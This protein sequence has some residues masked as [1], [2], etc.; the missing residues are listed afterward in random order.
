MLIDTLKTQ[1][2]LIA[3]GLNER[4]AKVIVRAISETS[5]QV[6]TKEDVAQ[7]VQAARADMNRQFAQ[8]D[9]RFEQIDKRFEQINE[10]FAQVDKRFGQIDE[11]FAQVDKRFGQI[12]KHFGQINGQFAQIDKQFGQMEG[13]IWRAAFTVAGTL[14]AALAIAVAILLAAG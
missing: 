9:K 3:G 8:V 10:Q 5:A 11:Q 4:Q 14:L 12:D 1:E 2:D 7:E 6:A 13:I